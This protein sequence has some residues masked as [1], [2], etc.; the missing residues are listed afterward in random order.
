MKLGDDLSTVLILFLMKNFKLLISLFLFSFLILFIN[1]ISATT[2]ITGYFIY[3]NPTLPHLNPASNASTP[4]VNN[5]YYWQGYTPTTLPHN[6]LAGLQGGSSGQYYHL[7]QS[8]YNQVLSY[9]YSWITGN[10]VAFLNQSNTFTYP[11]IFLSD[12]VFENNVN[13]G[14]NLIVNGTITGTINATTAN[15]NYSTYANF[16][17]YSNN[18]NYINGYNITNLPYVPYQ[19][20]IANVNLSGYNLSASNLFV[21][22]GNQISWDENVTGNNTLAYMFYNLTSK[23]LEM[24]V[25]HKL[26]QDWGNSTTIYGTATFESDAFFKNMSGQGLLI[27]TNVF[28]VGNI[29]ANDAHFDNVFAGN[30]CYSDGTNCTYVNTTLG[31]LTQLILSMNQTLQNLVNS[32]FANSSSDGSIIFLPNNTAN[33]NWTQ[34]NSTITT[35]AN[36]NAFSQTVPVTIVGGAGTNTST[37]INYYLTQ[38]IVTPPTNTTTYNFQATQN[39]ATGYMVDKNRMTHTG[40]WNIEKGYS[41][42][43]DTLY[44]NISNSSSNGLFSVQIKYIN[45]KIS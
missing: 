8:L 11:Q 23:R 43:N 6:L 3:D 7:N 9:A 4:N 34:V 16:S 37:V 24:W 19:G 25:N 44:L 29:T 14:G 30:V 13:I 40:I 39:N 38:L 36:V 42:T 10:N 41:L 15:A 45:N 21:P 22:L 12:A 31:N 33:L 28:V 5:S 1:S 18:S 35:I 2:S 26:Q 20:A 32:N 17:Y 27:N